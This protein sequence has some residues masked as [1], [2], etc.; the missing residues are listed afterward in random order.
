MGAWGDNANL[1]TT[2]NCY[3]L[4]GHFLDYV[5]KRVLGIMRELLAYFPT[6]QDISSV[7]HD[8]LPGFIE[9]IRKELA[10][11]GRSLPLVTSESAHGI[12]EK[13]LG[14][15]EVFHFT[16]ECSF[17]TD[18]PVYFDNEPVNKEEAAA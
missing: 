18:Q 4:E 17:A 14:E 5:S 11:I 9:N 15:D 13:R 16:V 2:M 6:S 10:T 1:I 3:D 7:T 8:S 12:V